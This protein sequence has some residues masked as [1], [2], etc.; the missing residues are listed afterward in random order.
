MLVTCGILSLVLTWRKICLDS[1]QLPPGSL[2][3][4]FGS[5]EGGLPADGIGVSLAHRGVE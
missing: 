5:A 4:P 3:E 1:I 2:A